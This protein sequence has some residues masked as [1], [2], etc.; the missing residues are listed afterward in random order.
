MGHDER[1]IFF[2]HLQ[3]TAGTSLVGRLRQ[4]LGE[5]AVYPPRRTD[6]V[7]W[8]LSVDRLVEHWQARR[9]ELRVLTGHFPYCTTTLL[10]TP[11]HTV[12]VL[13]HP[14]PRT[15]SYLRHHRKLTPE[16][17]DRPL[18]AIYD[19]PFRFRCMIHNHMVKMLGMDASEMTAGMITE[20][21]CTPAHL[22]RAKATLRRI[23][24]VGTQERY[25]SFWSAFGDRFGLDLGP[26]AFANQTDPVDV[27]PDFLE[28]IEA[29]NA[30]DVA[31]YEEA[32]ALTSTGEA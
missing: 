2:V 16:D 21:E 19:D 32:V 10:D 1:P 24:L 6:D 11:V 5:D 25:D 14:V 28:R 13:R 22:E 20:L 15:L 31:L 12:T 4:L 26:M 8:V 7:N 23:D 27:D 29:D 30:L 17:R 9:D 3:K 18:E